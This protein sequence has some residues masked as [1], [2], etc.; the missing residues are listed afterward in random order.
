MSL[1]TVKDLVVEFRDADT[2]GVNRACNHV[3]LDVDEGEIVGL[4]GE[5]GCGKSTLGRTI[6][7]L[8]HARSGSII[9]DGV[10]ILSLPGGRQRQA[11]RNLQ[12]IFQD[13]LAALEPRQTVGSAL[14]EALI[15]KGERNPRARAARIS[16]ILIATNLPSGILTRRPRELSG[17]Q[18]QRVC[19]ARALLAEPKLLICDEPVSSLDM[20]LRAQVMNLFLS[21]RDDLGVAIIL[22]AHDLS[23]VRQ[24]SARVNVMYLGRIVESGPSAELYAEPLHPYSHALT[25]AI[26]HVDPDIERNRERTVLKGDLPSPFAPPSG[27]SFRTRC[28]N[29]FETC[30]ELEPREWIEAGRSVRC[31][32]YDEVETKQLTM[33]Y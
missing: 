24:A 4:V 16:E 13:P 19:I 23:I 22:I 3:S 21:L 26:L 12:Y 14:D 32:L 28:P 9:F 8:E 11:R 20:S 33:A 7:G 15:I 5:S 10:D 6:V 29:A 18:R 2:G 27:C 25:S 17:G 31:H 1:L 30:A